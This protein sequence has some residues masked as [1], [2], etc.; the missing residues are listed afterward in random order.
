MQVRTA[1]RE[2]HA[3][4]VKLA[5]KSKYT[6]SFSSMMFSNEGIYAKGWITLVEAEGNPVGL[7]CVRHK[8]RSPK[9]IIYFMVTHPDYRGQGIGKLM[10][11]DLEEKTPHKTI[12]LSVM[13][14]NPGGRAF[15]ERMGF[16]P[17]GEAYKGKGTQM[18][19]QL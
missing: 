17:V 6:K 16:E 5:A 13:N 19:K 2:D 1:T 14:D 4:L 3:A 15:W 18:E 11:D 10:M 8:V 12:E 7:L 9:S